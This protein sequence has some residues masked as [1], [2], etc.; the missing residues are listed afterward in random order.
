MHY[1]RQAYGQNHRPVLDTFAG[2]G[3]ICE[4]CRRLADHDN[5]NRWNP[6]VAL[7]VGSGW[8]LPLAPHSSP[9]GGGTPMHRS[10]LALVGLLVTLVLV[11]V[12]C[13]G[14]SGGEA[15]AT[16]HA[17]AAARPAETTPG[18]TGAPEPRREVFG[19]AGGRR[20][21]PRPG[22]SPDHG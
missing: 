22:C 10:G 19:P 15:A 2:R 12:A 6:G 8:R 11:G 21:T 1:H 9:A 14:G 5:C 18:R 20:R 17:P 16:A 13:D 3:Q 7:G 4:L